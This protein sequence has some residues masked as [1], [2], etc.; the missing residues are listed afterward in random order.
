[1]SQLEP[2]PPN[3]PLPPSLW[4]ESAKPASQTMQLSHTHLRADVV[5]IGAGFTG[6]SAALQLAETGVDVVVLEAAELGWGASGRNNGQVIPCLSRA[7]PDLL[8]KVF[9]AQK[10]EAFIGLIR[11]SASTVFDLIRKHGIECEA[12][13]NGWVQPAHRPSRMSLVSAR[14]KQWKLRGAPVELLDRDQVTAITGSNYWHGGWQNPTGGHVNPL[15]LVR[16]LAAAAMKF[17]ARIYIQSPALGILPAGP[18]WRVETR[19]GVVIAKK[20][21]IA[22][23]AYS[24]TFSNS[25]WPGLDRTFIPIRS[26]QMATAPIPEGLRRGILPFNHA[27]SDTHGD[28]H[29]CRF[30]GVGRLITGGALVLHNNFEERLQRRIGTRLKDMFPALCELGPKPF[31]HIWHGNLAITADAVPHVHKLADGVYAWL[32]CNGRGLALATAIG[33][34]LADVVKGLPESKSPLPFAALEPIFSHSLAKRVAP[35]GLLGYRWRDG[36]D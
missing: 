19:D 16:G 4:T 17:G 15:G 9:G 6:L 33:G 13:Q 11:D 23:H 29:F 34:A 28:L 3:A 18:N 32:G 35:F 5:V 21:I 14:C 1:M 36:R 30:D 24:S 8:L 7:D 10:G 22:T 12:V 31:E 27:M 20:V 25:L 2:I 26:Y